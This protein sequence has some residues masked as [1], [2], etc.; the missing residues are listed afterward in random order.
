MLSVSL[1]PFV[2]SC[3]PTSGGVA[4]IWIFDPADFD[5][6]QAA[7]VSGVA[8]PYTAVALITPSTGKMYPINFIEFD[9]EYTY[10]QSRKACSVK[11]E[12]QLQFGLANLSMLITTWNQSID[13][14]GCC[15]GIGLVILLNSGKI[16]VAGERIVGGDEIGIPLRIKQD[17]SSGTSGK[18]LDDENKQD[19]ILKG[20]YTRAL[21]EY[22][23]PVSDIIGLE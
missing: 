19:T 9:A 3:A 13:A 7:P 16:F 21:Y 23:G 1:K 4:R 12:H 11:Y 18:L 17:G 2:Q 8:Q 15:Y 5:W 22:T 10:K 20:D 14:A 6:T